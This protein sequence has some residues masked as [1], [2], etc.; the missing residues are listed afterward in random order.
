MEVP[1]PV[2]DTKG[3][4]DLRIERFDTARVEVLGGDERQRVDAGSQRYVTERCDPAA[5]R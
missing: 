3:H 1:V 5:R 2:W 4:D